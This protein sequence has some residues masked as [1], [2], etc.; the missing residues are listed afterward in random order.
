MTDTYSA[1]DLAAHSKAY[2]DPL[3]LNILK[4]LGEGSFGVLELCQLFEIKQPS[5]SHHLKILAKAELVSTHREG[6][7]IFYRR[8]LLSDDNLCKEMTAELFCQV[9]KLSLPEQAGQ[10]L[11]GLNQARALSAQEFFNKHAAEFKEQQ[12]LIASHEQYGDTLQQLLNDLPLN[13]QQAIEI[14]P[15]EGAFL[16]P[17]SQRFEQVIALDVSQALLA[18]AQTVLDQ[19]PA[20]N[21]Q[22][23]H[24]ST[25]L[26]CQ[27]QLSANFICCNMVLHHVP[28]PKEIF[29]DVAKLLVKDSTSR[30]LITDLCL[31]DQEWAKD[32]CGDLWLGFAPQELT[33][34]AQQAGLIEDQSQYLG[35][36]NGFQIQFRIFKLNS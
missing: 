32:S 15:G 17:L 11:L 22:L 26:A 12:D 1:I 21:V 4:V 16:L 6:N 25:E 31:H 14:G 24:G 5:M 30:F 35:L 27:Q 20:D 34:W 8:A 10:R 33:L 7:S 36:R 29:N 3:R 13:T 28:T 19:S 18:K 9:D 23:M 2:A